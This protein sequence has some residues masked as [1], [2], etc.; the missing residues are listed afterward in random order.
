MEVILNDEIIQIIREKEVIQ[1]GRKV[2]ENAVKLRLGITVSWT[3]F[4]WIHYHGY[5]KKRL[6]PQPLFLFLI[7]TGNRKP[8]ITQSF[9]MN[10]MI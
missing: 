4:S 5:N 7:L 8:W 6:K 3:S 1:I 2:N 10:Q 9:E